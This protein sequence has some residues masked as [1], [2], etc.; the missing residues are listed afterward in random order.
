MAYIYPTNDLDRPGRY[1][2]LLGSVWADIYSGRGL[3]QD[4]LQGRLDVAKQAA[5]DTQELTAAISRQTVPIFHKELWR[6][7]YLRESDMSTSDAAILRYDGDT[8]AE[9]D[10]SP[11]FFYDVPQQLDFVF[12]LPIAM[13][14]CHLISNR[15]TEPSVVLHKNI[16]FRIDLDRQAVVF[17]KNPFEDE[18]IPKTQIFSAGTVVDREVA[19]WFFGAAFDW[20]HIYTHFGYV[21]G[22]RATSSEQYRDLVNAVLDATTGGTSLHQAEQLISAMAGI[23]LTKNAGEVVEDVREDAHS[24]LV[25]TDKEVYKFK[26]GTTATVAIGDVLQAG[27]SLITA[28]ERCEFRRGVVSDNIQAL[29]LGRGLL[30]PDFAGEL[31]FENK[32]V[33]LV[34]TGDTGEERVEFEINGHPLEIEYFWDLVHQNRLVYGSSLYELLQA[35]GGVPDTINP[36]EFL[37][38]NLLRNNVLA[39]R[40]AVAGF[41]EQALG[42]GPSIL[43]RRILPPH[44]TIILIVELP[45][46]AQSI[47]MANIVN[48]VMTNTIATGTG[49][50]S[51]T[52]ANIGNSN[53]TAKNISF[54]C[55]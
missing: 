48:T 3:L 22:Y 53:F 27:Q 8:A 40:L 35:N 30:S 33:D 19:L 23:P 55:Q 7:V 44:S 18:L 32:E 15:L 45:P 12:P 24:L 26:R 21:L 41:G 46:Q 13:Q 29:V 51:L 47:T 25:L 52:R 31:V 36:V 50:D 6:I 5:N 43:L 54:T 11:A 14:D 38:Q 4:R 16:N 37:V 10:G 9:Y 42:L 28:Y 1:L 20:E 39:V 49:S 17:L 2:E 34:V